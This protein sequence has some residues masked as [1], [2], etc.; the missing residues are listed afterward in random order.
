MCLTIRYFIEYSLENAVAEILWLIFRLLFPVC[1]SSLPEP[2]IAAM[3]N[4][5]RKKMKLPGEARPGISS[6]RVRGH[7][8]INALERLGVDDRR[9]ARIAAALSPAPFGDV[10]V[11]VPEVRLRVHA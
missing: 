9:V 8:R 3:T 2:R 11:V 6:E 4:E 5:K 1:H 7:L 10:R